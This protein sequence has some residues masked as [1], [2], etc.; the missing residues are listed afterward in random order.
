MS[1]RGIPQ[2]P[3]ATAVIVIGNTCV[4]AVM[5]AM[6]SLASGVRAMN[7]QNARADRIMIMS[8]GAQSALASNIE[9]SA[10]RII[11]D[12]P[13][14]KKDGE[15]KPLATAVTMVM[16]EARK[17]SDNA[18]V[19]F[20]MLGVDDRYFKVYPE[21][22]FSAG[23]VFQPA[24]NEIVV[25]QSRYELYQNFE[26][27]DR[28]HL[29][30]ADWSIVGRYRGSGTSDQSIIAD[31]DTVK[32]L[33]KR[34]TTQVI[35]A[36]LESP[37]ALER[38]QAELKANPNLKVEVKPELEVLL[39]MSKGLTG[40]MDFVSYFVAVVMGIGATL[41]AINVMYAVV[42]S[43]KREMATLRAMGFGGGPIV[44][45]VLVESILLAI[46]G[47]LLGVLIAW[48]AFNGDAVSTSGLIFHLTITP[49]LIALGMTWA[50]AMGLL[51]G[52]IPAIRAARVP[53][54]TALRAT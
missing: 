14:I 27:G 7:Q 5:L 29:R 45:S 54:A 38:V 11:M 32:S 48:G 20:P 50:V 17:K 16:A 8:E 18:R 21:L 52:I 34:N 43:R 44:L 42:D 1:L 3:G 4:V 9:T 6:L 26:I 25:S 40:L 37:A 41:G 2:R 39:D 49:V 24:V 46:P 31:V 33:Y 15:G 23:R 12:T 35:T 51:G 10:A 47:A 28:V 36:V 22:G 19:T 13:G 53:V 30:G